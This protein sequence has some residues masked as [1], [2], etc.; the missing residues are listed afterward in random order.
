ME[1]TL[2]PMTRELMHELYRGFV[3]DPAI[4]M[5]MDLYEKNKNYRYDAGKVDALFNMR[6]EEPGSIAFAVMLGGQ[7]I[8][9]VGLRHANAETAE[10]ELSIHLQNDSVKNKGYGTAAEQLAIRYAFDVLR[11]EHI[12]AECV[13]KNGR[14]RHVLEKLGFRYLGDSEGFAQ[15]RLD[16]ND[17]AGKDRPDA[18]I[19]SDEGE[20]MNGRI[21]AA[22]GND[23]SACPR[24]TA[25]PYEK[26]EEELRH[27]AVLWMR[28]GYR[29]R[30]VPVEEIACN[31][32]GP[33]NSCRYHVAAC[34]AGRGIRTCAE[35][36]EYPCGIMKDCFAVT[37]SFEPKCR[38]VCT[39]GEYERIGTAFFEKEKNLNALSDELK[40][41][42][43]PDA[44]QA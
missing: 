9:E 33:E 26:T 38:E 36:A 20:T 29:D 22:C 1:I 21:I 2:Q 7:V 35:C 11:M 17:T 42:K 4:F 6:S 12:F 31:G 14:S 13:I 40:G 23:C 15:Y 19:R 3:L 8:G 25:H 5:D 30:V 44:V 39:D 16:R 10:C 24:Y 43:T 32:C 37:A 41:R 34:C 27:T 18:P 28:I